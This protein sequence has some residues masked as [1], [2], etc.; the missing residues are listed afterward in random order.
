MKKDEETRLFMSNFIFIP[1][2]IFKMGG[3]GNK[4]MH[5]PFKH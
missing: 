4:N 2:Q 5:T 3:A 1:L